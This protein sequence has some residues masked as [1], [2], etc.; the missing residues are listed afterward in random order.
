[1]K[2]E[3]VSVTTLRCRVL[4]QSWAGNRPALMRGLVLALPF[5]DWSH[6]KLARGGTGSSGCPFFFLFYLRCVE[7]KEVSTIHYDY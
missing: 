6:V 3:E 7:M 4:G 5:S 1:M 2:F